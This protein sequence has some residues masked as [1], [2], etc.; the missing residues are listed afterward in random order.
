[1]PFV[2]CSQSIACFY[3]ILLNAVGS[4]ERLSQSHDCTLERS[5]IVWPF[6]V[7]H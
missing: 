1:M 2:C 6:P 5:N 4:D 7:F 3:E